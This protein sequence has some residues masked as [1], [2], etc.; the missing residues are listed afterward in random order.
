LANQNGIAFL[1]RISTVHGMKTQAD[2]DRHASEWRDI[3]L[4]ATRITHEWSRVVCESALR[5][6]ACRQGFS[7]SGFG[8]N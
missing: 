6:D 7:V 3:L 8:M 1:D 4:E 2:V 5:K